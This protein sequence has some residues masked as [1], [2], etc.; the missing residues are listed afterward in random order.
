MSDDGGFSGTGLHGRPVPWMQELRPPSRRRFV[1]GTMVTGLVAAGAGVVVGFATRRDSTSPAAALTPHVPAQLLDARAA[2]EALVVTAEAALR[3]ARGTDRQALRAVR[4]DHRAHL[5]ALRSA[6]GADAFPGPAPT[7]ASSAPGTATSPAT[8]GASGSAP[9]PAAVSTAQV[10]TAEQRA[11]KAAAARA[12]L[13]TGRDAA[14]LA[15]IAACEATHVELFGHAARSVDALAGRT[16]R[17]AAGRVRL[18]AARAAAAQLRAEARPAVPDRA[19]V[20]PRPGVRGHRCTGID[21]AR[22][23][24]RLSRP[25]TRSRPRH[26]CSPPASRTTARQPGAT[27][28]R[29]PRPWPARPRCA[30][31][32]RLVSRRAPCARRSGASRSGATCGRAVPGVVRLIAER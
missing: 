13:V 25:C 6:I 22:A 1:L 3:H 12:L 19:R 15:S 23:G 2:E 31:P 18:H 26:G 32:R 29:P 11:A 24:R 28:S 7:A 20:G 14:L 8:P 10:R 27:C 17:R 4:D 5:A 9:P 30:A 16:G 21:P